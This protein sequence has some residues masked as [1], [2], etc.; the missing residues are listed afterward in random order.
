MKIGIFSV[1]SKIPNLA[2]MKIS[3]FHKLNGDHVELYSP[4]FYDS[5]DKIYASKIFDWPH[6]NDNYIRTEKMIKGGPGFNLSKKLSDEIDHIY[7]DYKIFKCEYALGYITR[8]C[9]RSCPWCVVPKIEGQIHKFAELTEFCTDQQKVMLLDNN[10]LSYE[11]CIEELEKLILTKKR[12]E[13][14]QGFDIRLITEENALLL[15]E[16]RRWRGLRFKFA[17]DQIGIKEIIDKKLKIIYDAGITKGL[18]EFYVL[19]GYD[20]NY[21]QDLWRVNFLKEEG[22]SVFIMPYNKFDIYQMNFARWVNRFRYKF[23]S[24][25]EYLE[26]KKLLNIIQQV[27]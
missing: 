24:F 12:F 18:I 16:L 2:L 23:Q 8:G 13:F 10:F 25:E 15:R 11:K 7:P 5:Y 9:I 27:N 4:L 20:S 21:E 19:I 3:A 6:V 22:V 17:F 26:D 1:D 14:T